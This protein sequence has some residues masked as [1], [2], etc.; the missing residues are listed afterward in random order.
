MDTNKLRQIYSVHKQDY[1]DFQKETYDFISDL[2]I[3]NKDLIHVA[4]IIQRPD[5]KIKSV[6]SIITNL[7]ESDKYKNFK[8]LYDI[9]DIAGIRVICHCEDDVENF[10]VLLEGELNQ[11]YFVVQRKQIGG[12]GNEY[13]YRATHLT[14]AKKIQL[15]AQKILIFCEIQIR[16][17]MADAWAIQNHKYIYKKSSEGDSHELTNAVSEIMSGCEKLWSLVKKKSQEKDEVDIAKRISIVQ[18][19]TDHK[20]EKIKSTSDLIQLQNDW[21][22]SNSK[23][24]FNGFRDLG[25]KAYMEAKIRLIDLNLNSDKNALRDGARKSMIR[26]FGWPIGVFLDNKPEFA[27]KVDLDGI[28][29]EISIKDREWMDTE[30]RITYDYWAIHTSGAFYLLKSLFEDLRKPENIFFNTRIVR[31]TE[32]LLYIRNLYSF[33]DV[34]INTEIEVWIKHGG[35]KGR[36]LTA[37]SSNRALYSEYKINTD[38]VPTTIRTSLEEIEKDPVSIV[39]KFTEPLFEQFDFFKLDKKVLED[40]VLNFINGKAV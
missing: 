35:L 23:N 32:I 6:E 8:N 19:T 40:I 20:L 5:N 24:A 39:E 16:T 3:Q 4:G 15:E 21:F 38:E 14:F 36:I 31:I 22:F 25:I 28:H 26:T 27:P 1:Q 29:A 11:R 17:V 18:K 13:P 30:E 33:F 2:A 10:A 9:K 7:K 37:S 34:T 12:K